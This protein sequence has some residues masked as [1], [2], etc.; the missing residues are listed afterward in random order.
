MISQT[1]MLAEI[2]TQLPTNNANQ[3][4]AATTRGVLNDMVTY[5]TQ[6]LSCINVKNTPYNAAGNGIAD[7]STAILAAVNAAFTANPRLSVYFPAGTY[8]ITQSGVLTQ[9]TITSGSGLHYFGD[10]MNVSVL[11]LDT[12]GA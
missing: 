12:S 1:Q 6:T 8:R 3:I 5:S 9:N 11:Q 2:S 7:D 4:T 10:G